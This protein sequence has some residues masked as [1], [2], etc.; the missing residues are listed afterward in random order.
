M[1]KVTFNGKT[2]DTLW[3]SPFTLDV[4]DSLM[5]SSNQFQVVV[6][7]TTKDKPALG[8][9]GLSNSKRVIVR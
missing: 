8:R 2:Y 7:S 5:P 9:V 6:T 3:R 4:T 1:A